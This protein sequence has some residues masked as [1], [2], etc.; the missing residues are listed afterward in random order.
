M[1]RSDDSIYRNAAALAGL[2]I[3]V[4]C[5]FLIFGQYKVFGTQFTLHGGFE[6]WINRFLHDG[7]SYPFMVP[8]LQRVVLPHARAIA[9]LVG[10]GEL[11]IG[12]ALVAGIFVRGAS[13]SGFVYM[14]LLLFSS[15]YPG[16]H[17]A[18]WQY[19]GASLDHSVLAVCFLAF[20]CSC[21]DE[22][23]SIKGYVSKQWWANSKARRV[24]TRS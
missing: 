10:Y 5:L 7:A 23:F 3:A 17:V 8:V 1:R 2:R 22:A 11:A 13:L 12:I 6:G 19:F 16:D 9:F 24:L 4:G 18:L 14:L 15:N 20:I 21:S